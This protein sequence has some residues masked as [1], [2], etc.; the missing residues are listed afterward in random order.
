MGDG[1]LLEALISYFGY[2]KMPRDVIGIISDAWQQAEY[3]RKRSA[4]AQIDAL[5]DAMRKLQC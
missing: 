3:E 4:N 1:E 5:H 2:G